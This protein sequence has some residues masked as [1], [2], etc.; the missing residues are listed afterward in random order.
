MKRGLLAS[1]WLVLV[2]AAS[3]VAAPPLLLSKDAAGPLAG[4]EFAF[5]LYSNAA[6]DQTAKLI[7]DGSRLVTEGLRF[8]VPETGVG[9]FRAPAVIILPDGRPFVKGAILGTIGI[10]PCR[11]RGADARAPGVW[12]GS[13]VPAVATTTGSATDPSGASSSPATESS[14]TDGAPWQV[15][16]QAVELP[17]TGPIP[18]YQARLDGIIPAPDVRPGLITVQTD[19]LRYEPGQPVT[20][21]VRNAG[22]GPAAAFA[23]QSWCTIVRLERKVEDKWRMV[24]TCETFAPVDPTIIPPGGAVKVLLPPDAGQRLEAGIY[25]CV[26]IWASLGADGKPL[27]ERKE[28]ISPM[29]AVG[30]APPSG[31]IL[32]Y[33]TKQLYLP[34]EAATAV[35]ANQT[36]RDIVV[37]KWYSFCSLVTLERRTATGWQVVQPCMLT[38][39]PA[40]TIK[41]G[42]TLKVP[43]ETAPGVPAVLEPG[44]YRFKLTFSVANSAGGATGEPG[45]VYSPAFTVATAPAGRVVIEPTKLVYAPTEHIVALIH[46]GTLQKI[47]VF[48][49]QSY[50]SIV[51]LEFLKNGEWAL[52]G[53]CLLDR[54]PIPTYIDPKSDM[55]VALPPFEVNTPPK[56][57]PGKYRLTLTFAF[58][59]DDGSVT[60]DV[61]IHSVV[62]AVQGAEPGPVVVRPS[63]AEYLPGQLVTGII[64]NEMPS[65]IRLFD[66]NSFCSIITM[67]MLDAAGAWTPVYLCELKSPVQPVIL[68]PK[69]VT[70]V[71]LPEVAIPEFTYKPGTYRLSILFAPVN[72]DGT[73]LSRDVTLKSVPFTILGRAG[74]Q[75]RPGPQSPSAK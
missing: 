69:T 17:T 53:E 62:F 42:E 26:V 52:L 64:V 24:G 25:R 51:K 12:V 22:T 41:A 73:P 45:T 46:N 3:A 43:M 16:F 54:I 68:Q 23:P 5:A 9:W 72:A 13:F 7:P 50:C 21:I 33:P 35:I 18:M 34:G 57:E 75:A 27:P 39:G 6:S 55:K 60:P 47:R 19:K 15:H 36:T 63:Q 67:E 32:L 1:L 48:D 11:D 74:A 10:K 2:S 40:I 8:T 49:L 44:V 37:Y 31:R 29:F 56:W 20:A 28:A 4:G 58:V 38:G 65:P 14:E 30:A 70:K 66:H 61:T 59:K 71:G